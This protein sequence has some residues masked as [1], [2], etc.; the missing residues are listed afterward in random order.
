MGKDNI[1]AADAVTPSARRLGDVADVQRDQRDKRQRLIGS[2][3]ER[4]EKQR[5][6]W[7]A[8][9]DRN[10]NTSRA[11]MDREQRRQSGSRPIVF[12]RPEDPTPSAQTVVT[13]CPRCGAA[14]CTGHRR[15]TLP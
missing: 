5:A 12:D 11:W 9:Q 2:Q 15:I 14:V 7:Q 13:A 8:E 3:L 6:V 1:S 10:E 4:S